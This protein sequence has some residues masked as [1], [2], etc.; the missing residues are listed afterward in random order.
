MANLNRTRVAI[1]ITDGFEMT[2]PR[3]APGQAGALTSVVSRKSGNIRAWKFTEWGDE[4]S[5][6]IPLAQARSEDFDALVLPGS[7]MSPD[8]L[9]TQTP[10]VAFARR[11]WMQ[12]SRWRRF[13]TT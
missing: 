6:G 13:V 12:A 9:R 1:L 4:F 11:S 8:F 5:V 7:V 10:T 3:E 2:Q